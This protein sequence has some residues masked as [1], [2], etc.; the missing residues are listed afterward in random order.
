MSVAEKQ[1]S[2]YMALMNFGATI[3]GYLVGP[4]E[5]IGGV[6]ALLFAI[7]LSGLIA[8]VAFGLIRNDDR[9]KYVPDAL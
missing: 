1:F 3:A 2:L 8:A 9:A 6:N 5:A 7:S 4:V